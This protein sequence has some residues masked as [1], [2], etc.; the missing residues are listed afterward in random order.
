M[1]M[2]PFRQEL[3]DL[4]VLQLPVQA[5]ELLATLSKN[6]IYDVMVEAGATL[7]TAFL[8]ESWSMK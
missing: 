7:S 3:A 6:I 8:Q 5:L 1:V 4:G 2:G